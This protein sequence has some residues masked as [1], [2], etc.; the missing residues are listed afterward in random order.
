MLIVKLANDVQAIHAVQALWVE[1]W[2]G[3]GLSG[4][5][6][7]FEE[8][9]RTLPGKYAAPRGIL[10]IAYVEGSPAGTVAL[11][12]LVA[13][14]CELKR[15]YVRPQFRRQGVARRLMEWIIE[16]ARLLGYRTAHGDTLPTMN[17][18]LQFYFNLGFRVMDHPYSDNPTPGA[19]YLELRI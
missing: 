17:E 13:D 19:V 8:E 15:L 9:L 6:Q 11:R 1:Y 18:A 5:F 2:K 3:L 12:P 7:G 14:A 16:Q 4:D 10:A